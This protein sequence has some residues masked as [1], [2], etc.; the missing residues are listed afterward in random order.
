MAL[1]CAAAPSPEPGFEANG[2]CICSIEGGKADTPRPV[3]NG[4]HTF[5]TEVCRGLRLR[6]AG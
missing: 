1:A 5:F 6:P 3:G 4:R 2:S